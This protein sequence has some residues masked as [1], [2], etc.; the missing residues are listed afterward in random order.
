MALTFEEFILACCQA[1][2]D[3]PPGLYVLWI[4]PETGEWGLR[5]GEVHLPWCEEVVRL[6][7]TGDDDEYSFQNAAEYLRDG[8]EHQPWGSTE[9]DFEEFL[10]KTDPS[11]FV[12]GLTAGQIIELLYQ[13]FRVYWKTKAYE[14]KRDHLGQYNIVSWYH[15]S[16]IGLTHQDGVTLNGKPDE[17]FCQ[18]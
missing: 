12:F 6:S 1:R 17:F 10:S 8:G 15:N 9:Q 13:G 14:V 4:S 11:K 18:P 3:L 7:E 16:T 5:K 2:Q